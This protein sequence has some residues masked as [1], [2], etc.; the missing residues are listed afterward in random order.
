[1]RKAISILVVL[2]ATLA[3]GTT[4]AV[5]QSSFQVLN[6]SGG[7]CV[8]N[9]PAD[10]NLLRY[11]YVGVENDSSTTI[12]DVLCP[13]EFEVSSPSSV[14][15]F[16]MAVRVRDRSTSQQFFCYPQLQTSTG[17][18]YFGSSKSTG[19]SFTGRTTLSWTDPFNGG[20]PISTSSPVSVSVYCAV[21][22]NGS[23]ITGIRTI[24]Y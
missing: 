5:A 1:M 18:V 11:W 13:V 17:S 22:S 7:A 6:T 9:L 15:F 20:T 8:G 10:H 23:E 24:V 4:A 3:V 21:P 14:D 19:T 16:T 12:A 2:A